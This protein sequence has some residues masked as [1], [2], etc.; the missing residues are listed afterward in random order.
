MLATE[1][2]KATWHDRQ[3]LDS[4]IRKV[5]IKKPKRAKEEKKRK[6]LLED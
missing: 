1:A 6:D 5:E 2:M 3:L 4:I